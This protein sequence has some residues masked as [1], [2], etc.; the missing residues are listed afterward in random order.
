MGTVERVNIQ[1]ECMGGVLA[2][3]SLNVEIR[4]QLKNQL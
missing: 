4:G 1:K 2:Q 3:P